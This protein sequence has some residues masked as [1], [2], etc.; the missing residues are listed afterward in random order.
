LNNSHTLFHHQKISIDKSLLKKIIKGLV[1]KGSKKTPS[2]PNLKD[3]TRK[4]R[5]EGVPL[6]DKLPPGREIHVKRR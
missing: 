4:L 2:L 1:F 5:K 3:N 6:F